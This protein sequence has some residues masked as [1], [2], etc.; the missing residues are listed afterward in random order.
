M[1]SF[2][3]LHWRPFLTIRQ[4]KEW[5]DAGKHVSGDRNNRSAASVGFNHSPGSDL[6]LQCR[7]EPNCRGAPYQS[8]GNHKTALAISPV[9]EPSPDPSQGVIKVLGAGTTRAPHA[10]FKPREIIREVHVGKPPETA[11]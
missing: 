9:T 1:I 4:V 2:G 6:R 11:R 5:A 8:N 10:K 7:K 3:L